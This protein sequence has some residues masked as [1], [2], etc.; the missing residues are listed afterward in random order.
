MSIFPIPVYNKN[1]NT[2]TDFLSRDSFYASNH[3][4]FAVFSFL[5]KHCI[6]DIPPNG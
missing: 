5:D 4:H 6:V 1:M 3:L 2:H